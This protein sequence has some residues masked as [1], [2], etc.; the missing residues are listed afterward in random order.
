MK[1][2]ESAENYLETIYVLSRRNGNVRSIDIA[3]ELG[4]AKASV[5]VAMKSL[6]ENEYVTVNPDGTLVLTEKGLETAERVYERHEVIAGALM[7]L[8]VDKETA[9][10]DSCKIEHHISVQ[11][12]E[13]IK[14]YLV[15]KKLFDEKKN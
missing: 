13:K 8:G 2:Q 5:S 10:A 4:F 9:Y 15:D 7:A 1:I 6:R 3:N 12:V 14:Q 11:S